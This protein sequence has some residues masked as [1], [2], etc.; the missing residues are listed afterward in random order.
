MQTKAAEM[1]DDGA[2]CFGVL[3]EFGVKG[4]AELTDEQRILTFD[5][6]NKL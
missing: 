2:A 6:V 4:I 1:G 5:K 3:G